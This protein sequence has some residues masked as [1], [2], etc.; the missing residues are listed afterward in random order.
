VFVTDEFLPIESESFLKSWFI[1]T[2]LD[3]STTT[4]LRIKSRAW[5][6]LKC[7]FLQ[8]SITCTCRL[9]LT[10]VKSRSLLDPFLLV[11][12]RFPLLRAFAES[13]VSSEPLQ[14]M[15]LWPGFSSYRY[16]LSASAIRLGWRYRC[17]P[18][19]AESLLSKGS[20]CPRILYRIPVP[21]LSLV[22]RHLF[23]WQTIRRRVWMPKLWK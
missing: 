13:S 10:A 16:V 15:R 20:H 1:L 18:Y 5:W 2:L 19:I 17:C 3:H 7:Q 8:L 6:S 4:R 22:K 12:W 23:W 11:R 14:H 9:N 21:K